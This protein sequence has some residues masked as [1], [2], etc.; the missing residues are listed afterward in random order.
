[1]AAIH[2]Q[3][4]QSNQVHNQEIREA[5]RQLQD[6]EDRGMPLMRSHAIDYLYRMRTLALERGILHEGEN[7]E[8]PIRQGAELQMNKN[9]LG[10]N[11]IDLEDFVDGEPV[12]VLYNEEQVKR[13]NQG[14]NVRITPSMVFKPTS[15]EALLKSG[16]T[17]NPTT[18]QP[19]VMREIRTLR[20]RNN[21]TGG[22]RKRRKTQRKKM[23]KNRKY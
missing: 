20:F 1:M 18:R 17:L 4:N 7:Q 19:I 23:R 14:E 9:S 5:L 3:D 8:I 13:L 6:W 2:I 21:S 12:E 16:A 22:K 15:V 11:A 10:P